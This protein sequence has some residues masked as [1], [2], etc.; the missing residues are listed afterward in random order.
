MAAGRRGSHY[1]QL[2]TLRLV[3]SD[4]VHMGK[5]TF[6][7]IQL[8]RFAIETARDDRS[9]LASLITSAGYAHDYASP[10]DAEAVITEPA[11]HGRW[12]RSSVH[13]ELLE[14]WTAADAKSLLQSWAD[15][16]EWTDPNYGQPA[17]VHR[18]LQDVYAVLRSADLYKLRNPGAEDEHDYGYGYGYVSTSMKRWQTFRLSA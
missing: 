7:W 18:R 16:Q 2:M 3:G 13:A 8:T 10:F 15:E 5:G 4:I 17:A 12:W 6:M 11:I 14:P 9:L 1:G